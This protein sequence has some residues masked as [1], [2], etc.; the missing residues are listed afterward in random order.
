MPVERNLPGCAGAD[1]Y[2]FLM[3]AGSDP[4]RDLTFLVRILPA[5]TAFGDPYARYHF[6]GRRRRRLPVLRA[7]RALAEQAVGSMPMIE[8]FIGLAVA[9]ALGAYLLVTL[10][11]PERF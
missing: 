9:V 11:R 1:P 4:N 5:W 8:A 7:L 2:A 10:L 3:S 6:R